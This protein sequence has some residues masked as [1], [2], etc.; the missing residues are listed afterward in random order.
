[1]SRLCL[2]ILF[3]GIAVQFG[4][5]ENNY[6]NFEVDCAPSKPGSDKT[7]L[8]FFENI[9]EKLGFEEARNIFDE[10]K[11]N[12]LPRTS[13][14]LDKKDSEKTNFLIFPGTLWCGNGDN[15]KNENDLGPSNRTD[16]CCRAHDNCKNYIEAGG[17]EQNLINNGLFT[18]S[19]CIC[20]DEFYK[21]LRNVSSSA[22]VA[23][24]KIYFN[25]LKPQ[26]FK[27]IC[28]TDG[29]NSDNDLASCKDRC[30]KYKWVDNP[31]FKSKEKQ[32][33]EEETKKLISI[34]QWKNLFVP[35]KS[36]YP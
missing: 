19:A 24:G 9:A 6:N 27:C 31:K 32:E 17:T 22:S 2:F 28:P 12:L 13:G 8:S 1:M 11:N 7:R 16:A 4:D 30:T 33:I 18:R 14:V 35:I 21:C 34:K 10:A 23:V 15:A 25:L 5:C 3:L 20:D 26:C 36:L 29:C